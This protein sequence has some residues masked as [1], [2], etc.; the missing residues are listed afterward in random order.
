VQPIRL[1][2]FHPGRVRDT[3]V[4]SLHRAIG[5]GSE[6]Q[7]YLVAQAFLDHMPV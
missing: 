4:W 2:R 6:A 7:R 5:F 3:I 1:K